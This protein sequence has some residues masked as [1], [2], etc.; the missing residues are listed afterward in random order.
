[1]YC[2]ALHKARDSHRSDALTEQLASPRKYG[3]L[4]ALKSHT[5]I[6]KALAASLGHDAADISQVEEHAVPL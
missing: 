3:S 2:I 6:Q 5:T 1:M 4:R